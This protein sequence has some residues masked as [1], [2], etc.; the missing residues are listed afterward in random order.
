MHLYVDGYEKAVK[1]IHGIQNPTGSILNGTEVYF[2]HD[3]KVIIDEVEMSN[4]GEL[5]VLGSAIDIGPNLLIAVVAV[6]LIFAVAWLLRRALQLVVF[7][8]KP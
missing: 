6:A 2:G 5:E 7:R 8:S 1:A 4:L 3:S